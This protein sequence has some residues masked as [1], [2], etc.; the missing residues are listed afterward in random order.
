MKKYDF[1][2]IDRQ[3]VKDL[4]IVVLKISQPG[5]KYVITRSR[6]NAKE[7]PESWSRDL[8]TSLA[9]EEWEPTNW[10]GV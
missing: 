5:H 2:R 3:T 8:V 7:F 10:M 9:Y 1:H 6:F 4:G